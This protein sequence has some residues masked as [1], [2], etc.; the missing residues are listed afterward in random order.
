MALAHSYNFEAI[1]TLWSIETDQPLTKADRAGMRRLI[2]DFDKTYSRFRADS[3]VT[4][5]YKHAP[6]SFV[7]PEN[8]RALYDIYQKL[9]RVTDGAVNP[10]VGKSLEHWGYDAQYR[11]RPATTPVQTVV[12]FADTVTL[13]DTTLIYVQPALLDIGAIGKGLLVDMVSEY[14]ASSTGEYVV[15]AGGDMRIATRA[16]YVVGLENPN[17]LSQV[18]GTLEFTGKSICASS[19]NRR[20]WGKGLHHIID[21]RTGKPAQTDIIATWAIADT[22]MMADAL[23]TALFFTTPEELQQ[24]FGDFTYVVMKQN[25]EVVHNMTDTSN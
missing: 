2:D 18:I 11:L 14:V 8:I 3:T 22:A 23:S 4:R 9:E 19:P 20:T 12:P 7:F 24:V 25:F 10:L 17:D 13:K 6:G 16:P 15:E 21:A 5:A 1:G